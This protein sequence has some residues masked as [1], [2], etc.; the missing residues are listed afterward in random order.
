MKALLD[1]GADPNARNAAGA[2]AIIW[3]GGDPAKVKLLLARHA[4]VNARSGPG[5]TALLVAASQ[6]GSYE[7]VRA[8]I[9]AGADTRTK[10]NL[11]GPPILFTAGG[12]ALAS[13]KAAKARDPGL[14]HERALAYQR[15]GDVLGLPSTPNLGRTSQAIS[16]YRKALEIQGS[17]AQA[18]PNDTEAQT[19]LALINDRLCIIQQ[20]AGG[21]RTALETCHAAVDIRQKISDQH[22]DNPT[23]RA[24]LAAS[25]QNL[26]SS[27]FSVGD[28]GHT[29]S[30]AVWLYPRSS[31]FTKRIQL[32]GNIS[33]G[34]H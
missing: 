5:R 3:A 20:S 11:T 9:N 6:D 22:P 24:Q 15:I 13:I 2:T 16:S 33:A 29:E 12:G 18:N 28:W 26:S 10:H 17:L 7:T 31:S 19:N 4:D 32:T 34:W 21:F 30:S 27:Y 23:L 1:R 8:L 14:Q 25:Y